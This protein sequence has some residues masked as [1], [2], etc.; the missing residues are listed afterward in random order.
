MT[1]STLPSGTG[2]KGGRKGVFPSPPHITA[3]SVLGKPDAPPSENDAE[4]KDVH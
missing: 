2:R 1:R 4:Q 3:D